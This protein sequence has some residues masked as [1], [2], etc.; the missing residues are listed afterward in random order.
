MVLQEFSYQTVID[1]IFPKLTKHKKRAWHKFHVSL[2]SLVLQN[3]THVALLGKEISIMNLGEASKIMHDPVSY[4]A[5]LFTHEHIG[6]RYT[7]ENDPNDSMFWAATYF[8]QAMNKITDPNIKS[9]LYKYQKDLKIRIPHEREDKL[10]IKQNIQKKK[11]EKEAR[12][13][14]AS[15]VS[16]LVSR[17]KDKR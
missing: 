2:D 6:F 14:V 10:K 9:H 4:L 7:H 3:S 16:S 15:L 12:E 17:P 1:G 8:Q 5:N 11:I 13:Q